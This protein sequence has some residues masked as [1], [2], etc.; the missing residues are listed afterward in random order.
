MHRCASA[1]SA[2]SNPL[3]ASR[4]PGSIAHVLT[5][6]SIGT[7]KAGGYARYLEA[8]TIAPERGDYYL[9]PTGEP[10]QAHGRWLASADTLARF[11]IKG[12]SVQGRDFIALMEGRHPRSGAWLRREGAGGGRGG[13]V[14]L[15]FSAPK[16]VSV[17]WALGDEQSRLDIEDS[18]AAAVEQ[19]VNHLRESVATTT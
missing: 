8:K 2:L 12:Q 1:V 4:R 18:H 11:G 5:A 16:S 13:G 14:D 17:L 15:T 9:S 3:A 7:A 6:A 19:A 10:Q